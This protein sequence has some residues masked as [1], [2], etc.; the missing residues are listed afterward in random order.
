MAN[1]GAE[2]VKLGL[3]K[4]IYEAVR[5][6]IPSPILAKFWRFIFLNP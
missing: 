1:G 6:Q 3:A 5:S 2:M 4:V